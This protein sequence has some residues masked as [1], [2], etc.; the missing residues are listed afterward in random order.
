VN[1]SPTSVVAIVLA[2][3][4]CFVAGLAWSRSGRPTAA[5]RGAEDLDAERRRELE[6]E[7]EGLR[8]DIA[9]LMDSVKSPPT[10][11]E[12][13]P[14]AAPGVP[15]EIL[16]RLGALEDSVRALQRAPRDRAPAAE[17]QPAQ[18]P[19]L[20]DAQRRAVDLSADE[21][22]RLAALK[23]LR[24]QKIAGQ[25]AISRD[26][27]LSMLDLAEHSSDSRTRLDVYRNLHGVKD[28]TLRDSMLR[29]L[30]SD[31]DAK[32]REKVAQDLD[33][34]LGDPVVRSAL[35]QAAD[36]DPDSGVRAAAAKTLAEGR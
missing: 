19:D 3:L 20:L 33:T 14:S 32:V 35:Q 8:A 30:A 23:A 18:P 7:I 25:D 31:P 2:V 17:A 24:G 13:V 5:P 27:L 4:A 36:S 9:K 6:R 15:P 12:P 10:A 11:R 26:V 29:A 1:K 16:Q 28:T 34:F 21:A 22:Q